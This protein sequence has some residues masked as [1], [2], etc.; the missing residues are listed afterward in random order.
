MNLRKCTSRR[1][2]SIGNTPLV[3]L[4]SSTCIAIAKSIHKM[5]ATIFDVGKHKR[6]FSN[7]VKL[8]CHPFSKHPE[9]QLRVKCT[10]HISYALK[11]TAHLRA[12]SASYKTTLKADRGNSVSQQVQCVETQEKHAHLWPLSP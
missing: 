1:N 5:H 4:N 8:T 3:F 6:H 7:T 11:F 10:L 9:T 2:P 12:E